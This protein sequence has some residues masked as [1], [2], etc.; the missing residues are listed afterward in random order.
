MT[1]TEET[2]RVLQK[3]NGVIL[4][5]HSKG[6]CWPHAVQQERP[7]TDSTAQSFNS[8][9]QTGLFVQASPRFTRLCRLLQSPLAFPQGTTTQPG[10]PTEI[11]NAHCQVSGHSSAL[12]SH[13]STSPAMTSGTEP[14]HF[15][16]IRSQ[17]LVRRWRQKHCLL[18]FK[19][20]PTEFALG[21]YK[22]TCKSAERQMVARS[23]ITDRCISPL[24]LCRSPLRSW[25]SHFI[26]ALIPHMNKGHIWPFK[27][28]C[29]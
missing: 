18:I 15:N 11:P 6:H 2:I 27:V 22:H 5:Y 10:S 8:H 3:L 25:A 14:L 9:R 4:S 19:P 23:L 29:H 13:P 28:L 17:G 26:A 21:G 24:S 16:N 7:K 1:M 12:T 20:R